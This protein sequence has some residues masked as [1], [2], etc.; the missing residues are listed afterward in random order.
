M[1]ETQNNLS[2]DTFS[3]QAPHN[4]LRIKRQFLR[5]FSSDKGFHSDSGNELLKPL[6]CAFA[7]EVSSRV[8]GE[9]MIETVKEA[10]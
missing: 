5:T 10:V 6:F 2:G 1:P 8:L 4:A 7:E 3:T 9:F